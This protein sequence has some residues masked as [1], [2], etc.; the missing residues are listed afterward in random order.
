MTIHFAHHPHVHAV[1]IRSDSYR[2]EFWVYYPQRIWRWD[3]NVALI[4]A[5]LG[6][7]GYT[8]WRK[9]RSD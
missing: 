3:S 9:M 4:K 6:P 7:F 5:R 8:Y 1:S 2:H